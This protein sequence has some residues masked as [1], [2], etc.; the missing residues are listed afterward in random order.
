MDMPAIGLQPDFWLE[1]TNA[2]P[3]SPIVTALKRAQ[4]IDIKNH[5]PRK[6]WSIRIDIG[7]PKDS[8]A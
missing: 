3:N 7:D 5:H 2:D 1:Q 4:E 6:P 8:I